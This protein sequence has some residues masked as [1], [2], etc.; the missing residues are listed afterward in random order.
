MK[1]DGTEEN[2]YDQLKAAIKSGDIIFSVLAQTKPLSE[3]FIKQFPNEEPGEEI[4]IGE[5]RLN[6]D[7]F[8]SVFGDEKLFFQHRGV[9]TDRRFWNKQWR[10]FKGGDVFISNKVPENI[11]GQAV[12]D[13]WPTTDLEAAEEKWIAQEAEF[14]CPFE[15]LLKKYL[16]EPLDMTMGGL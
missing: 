4:K 10:S 5:I 9:N 3:N 15:W 1:A 14:G 11:Y 12:P 13:T 7:L 8:T 2:W 16:P 6:S